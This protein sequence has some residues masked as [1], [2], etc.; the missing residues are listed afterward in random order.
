MTSS[1]NDV[2]K[3][4]HMIDP[5][6]EETTGHTHKGPVKCKFEVSFVKSLDNV[7]DNESSIGWFNTPWRLGDV[8]AM[9]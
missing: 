6:W 7:L 2:G 5:L 3:A 1:C 8:S 9:F 4:F